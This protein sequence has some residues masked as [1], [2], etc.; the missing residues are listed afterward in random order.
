[1]AQPGPSPFLQRAAQ[2]DAAGDHD[3]A[4]NE[5]ARGTKAGDVASTRALG[6]RLLSGDRAPFLPA[7]GLGFIADVVARGNG[8][9]AARAAG[10][11]A[12][13]V[14]QPPNWALALEWL[15]RS[16]AAG[17]EPSQRQLLALCD[18]RARVQGAGARSDWRALAAAVDLSSWLRA[19]P[20]EVHHQ[21]PRI[22]GF[23]GLVRRE[24][25]D[26]LVSYAYGRLE[27]AKVYDPVARTDIVYAH[28][29]NTLATFDLHSV[30]LVHA[31]LQGRM[32]A[33]CGIPARFME[34]PSLLHYAPGEQ[35]ANHYDFVDP[36]ST[37]DYTGEIAR[38]GQ[39]VVTFLVYLNE[40]YEGGETDFP[41]LGVTHKGRIGE[42]FY[43][44]NAL[45]DMTS[46]KRTLHAG[47]PTRRGEKWIVTQFI[48]SRP[49]R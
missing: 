46:D 49:T 18:D 43:F 10:V 17:W 39:R 28:R 9:A 3:E 19:P 33:A 47:R 31:L 30:E 7:Q 36:D 14:H 8:E 11:L 13:G 25:C 26:C 35:I 20:A 4:I 24:I 45:P 1:M 40:D 15:W 6:L 2:R 29:S 48:R 37:P 21:D 41:N 42:G 23:P 12:L 34:A 16:A 38:N 44:V 32:A 5:L 22:A 27:P